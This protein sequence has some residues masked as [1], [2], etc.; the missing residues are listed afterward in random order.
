MPIIA[1]ILNAS[2]NVAPN[3]A[4]NSINVTHETLLFTQDS[5]YSANLLAVSSFLDLVT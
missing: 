5:I 4:P 1:R 3:S 2:K